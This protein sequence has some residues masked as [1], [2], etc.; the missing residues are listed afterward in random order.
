MDRDIA[1]YARER[2]TGGELE[3]LRRKFAAAAS[4]KT[5]IKR[6]RSKAHLNDGAYL[7]RERDMLNMV[8]A[9]ER[10]LNVEPP[11]GVSET[12]SC[13]EGLT[14]AL[15]HLQ[16]AYDDLAHKALNGGV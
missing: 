13:I 3:Y 4:M 14:A 6:A 1:E 16:T 5:M 9:M 10:W 15:M 12:W 11:E 8:E 7:V 2:L